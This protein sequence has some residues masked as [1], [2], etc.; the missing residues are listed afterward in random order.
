MSS[1]N[2]DSQVCLFSICIFFQFLLLPDCSGKVSG[3]IQNK[4]G[5]SRYPRLTRVQR[6]CFLFIHILNAGCGISICDI[7]SLKDDLSKPISIGLFVMKMLDFAKAFLCYRDYLQYLSFFFLM[8]LITFT[9]L[10]MLYYSYITQNKK[11]PRISKEYQG[12]S[13]ITIL[14]FKTYYE[15]TIIIIIIIKRQYWYKNRHLE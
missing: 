13:R 15:A 12:Y 2:K 1:A 7:F 4:R 8:W 11:K 10:Y 3:T 14:N 6:K 9:G 5:D